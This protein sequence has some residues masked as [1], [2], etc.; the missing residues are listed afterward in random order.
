[1]PM[2]KAAAIIT[3]GETGAAFEVRIALVANQLVGNYSG[4]EHCAHVTQLLHDRLNHVFELASMNSHG[5]SSLSAC[6][7]WAR[8]SVCRSCLHR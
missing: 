2:P 4:T 6:G 8:L 5:Q 3:K 7:K 1:M